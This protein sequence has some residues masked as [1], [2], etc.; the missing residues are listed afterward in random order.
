MNVI[1]YVNIKGLSQEVESDADI[2]FFYLGMWK[3]EQKTKL[4]R[5]SVVPAS[6]LTSCGKFLDYAFFHGRIVE[7]EGVLRPANKVVVALESA[8]TF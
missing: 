2:Q 8:V 6:A 3:I 5:G 1:I 7:G 4:C